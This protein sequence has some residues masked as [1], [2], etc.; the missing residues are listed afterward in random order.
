[1][2]VWI[3][4]IVSLMYFFFGFTFGGF[5]VFQTIKSGSPEWFLLVMGAGFLVV[6]GLGW[7][8]NRKL[9]LNC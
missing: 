8:K 3:V 2:G 6:G 9:N 1:M 4:W 7:F 5:G